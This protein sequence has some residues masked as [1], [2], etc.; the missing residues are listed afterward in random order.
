MYIQT[1]L[2]EP[3]QYFNQADACIYV[4][5][6][7]D[8]DRVYNAVSYFKAVLASFTTL[9]IKPSIHILL[10]KAERY[11]NEKNVRD[12]RTMRMLKPG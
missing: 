10:H 11:L 3:G 8:R 2:K 7:Q 9:S 12:E 1:Y 4:V 5:D 6:I